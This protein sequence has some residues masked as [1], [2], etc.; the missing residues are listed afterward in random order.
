MISNSLRLGIILSACALC[1]SA[2]ISIG[3]HF[4][5]LSSGFTEAYLRPGVIKTLFAFAALIT[6]QAFTLWKKY[7]AEKEV[8]HS[9]LPDRFKR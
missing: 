6:W 3:V 7:R 4:F 5:F 9:Q 2:A 8:P 1:I